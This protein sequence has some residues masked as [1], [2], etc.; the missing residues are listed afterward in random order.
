MSAIDLTGSLRANSKWM[1]MI[2]GT[3]IRKIE[4]LWNLLRREVTGAQR[5]I[6]S[7]HALDLY[8]DFEQPDR[9]GLA[10]FCEERPHD[11]PSLKAIGIE[12]RQRQDGRWSLRIY[13]S[14]PRLLPVF[15]ELCRDII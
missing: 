14:E 13:L 9:P 5:R 8:A 3:M 4:D 15:A 10:L 1:G 6:D 2:L 12:R 7:S 11:A